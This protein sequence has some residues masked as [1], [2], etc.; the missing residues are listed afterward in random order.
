MSDLEQSDEDSVISEHSEEHDEENDEPGD[1]KDHSELHTITLSEDDNNKVNEEDL[2]PI[3]NYKMDN[4]KRGDVI[5]I[6]NNSFGYRNN[7]KYMWDGENAIPLAY[8]FDYG[9]VPQEFLVGEE[10]PANY[11][12]GPIDYNYMIYARFDDEVVDKVKEFFESIET[13]NNELEDYPVLIFEFREEKWAM[14]FSDEAEAE[15]FDEDGI[16][17]F[18]Y[19]SM[20]SPDV[21]FEYSK[22]VS[23]REGIPLERIIWNG[24][25]C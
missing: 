5:G 9:H 22:E 13:R 15:P 11:W 16:G 12:E 21:D 4:W 24:S 2:S 19:A 18:F 6:L 8:E 20:D 25:Y 1:M 17:M 14:V 7:D 3:A 23:E 10:F